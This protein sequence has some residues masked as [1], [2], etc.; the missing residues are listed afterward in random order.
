MTQHWYNQKACSRGD[1][2]K[3]P[4][5]DNDTCAW[6]PN[7]VFSILWQ[8]WSLGGCSRGAARASPDYR[9]SRG[10]E[11]NF[12]GPSCQSQ[13]KLWT[14]AKARRQFFD[15]FLAADATWGCWC[16]QAAL[17]TSHVLVVLA[18]VASEVPEGNFFVNFWA[19]TSK[20]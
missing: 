6:T 19:D 9:R 10:P 7:N 20:S 12:L 14:L 17:G 4:K 3:W 13:S 8:S 1:S 16:Y 15:I 11:G 5:C 18:L 2:K